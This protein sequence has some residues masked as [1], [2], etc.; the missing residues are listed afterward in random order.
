MCLVAEKLSISPSELRDG[1]K[2]RSS[3]EEDNWTP[4]HRK[5]RSDSTSEEVKEQVKDYWIS[6][7]PPWA[8]GKGTL[9]HTAGK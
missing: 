4:K 8:I 5:I 9:P 1:H 6:L 7:V 2:K 3:L